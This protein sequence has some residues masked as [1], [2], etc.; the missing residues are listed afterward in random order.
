MSRLL[1]LLLVFAT[2]ACTEPDPEEQAQLDKERLAREIIDEVTPYVEKYI[3][4]MKTRNLDALYD[5]YSTQ[6]RSQ[7]KFEDL[8]KHWEAVGDRYVALAKSIRVSWIKPDGIYAIVQ[9]KSMQGTEH[10]ALIREDEVWKIHRASKNLS[11]LLRS[12]Q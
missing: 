3:E 7:F 4:N 5:G 12:L 2:C 8:K 9:L 10:I 6:Y 11:L 1:C